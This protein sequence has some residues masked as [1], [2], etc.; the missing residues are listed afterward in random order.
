M[1]KHLPGERI[2]AEN[3]ATTSGE[4]SPA[5]QNDIDEIIALEPSYPDLL[6]GGAIQ[7]NHRLRDANEDQF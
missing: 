1:P 6:T 5:I 3:L 4:N 7:R 2:E